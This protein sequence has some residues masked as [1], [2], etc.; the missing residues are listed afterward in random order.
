MATLGSIGVGSGV[1]I[2]GSGVRK[3]TSGTSGLAVIALVAVAALFILKGG[4]K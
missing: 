3:A 2:A 4:L 1:Y